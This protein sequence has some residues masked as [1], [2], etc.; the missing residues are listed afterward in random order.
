MG[1]V[2]INLQI[3]TP[4][5]TGDVDSKSDIIRSTGIV[6][7]L[8]WWAETL[9]RGMDEFA[10]DP[11]DDSRCP[12]DEKYCSS[13]LI[14]GA[15][16]RRRLFRIEISGG[17]KISF[18]GNGAINVKPSG[19]SRGWFF[20]P[21]IV[22]ELEMKII[23]LNEKF[24]ENFVLVPLIIA[25]KWGGI[26]AKTQLGYG[27]VE[28]MNSPS[29][30]FE[31]F[32]KMLEELLQKDRSRQQANDPAFPS[33]KEMFFAKVQFKARRNWWER[34]DGIDERNRPTI[35]KCAENG[36]VPIAP[37]I[38][39]WLRYGNGRQTWQHNGRARGLENWLFGTS[40]TVCP[41]CYD[42]DIVPQKNGTYKCRNCN[43][44]FKREEVIDRCA[45]KINI[46]C[47]YVVDNNLW[48]VRIWGWI[49]SYPKIQGFQKDRFLDNLKSALNGGSFHA[50]FGNQTS[51]HKL[52]VWREYNSVR[53]TFK[54]E[55]ENFDNF[56]ESLPKGDG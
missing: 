4:I 21:G 15:T 38:K 1:G 41:Q 43:Q 7:S 45:S 31:G 23:P 46:S 14:F 35:E 20:G 12:D 16:G 26:G 48:E 19:R 18:P 32:R 11:T 39:N 17:K 52:V 28:V 22:G 55:E 53:D 25:S 40:K 27:V 10:C 36:F 33:L 37:V 29:G 30:S 13:C 3:K 24:D 8:R 9:L 56:V 49:P 44:K 6:G 51:D 34:I 54:K 47:A 50:L 5:W 2:K 42:Y